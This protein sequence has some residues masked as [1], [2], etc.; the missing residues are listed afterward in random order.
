MSECARG[1]VSKKNAYVD[2]GRHL[3]ADFES[4]G[5]TVSDLHHWGGSLRRLSESIMS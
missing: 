1:G 5:L 4:V 3:I 2:G